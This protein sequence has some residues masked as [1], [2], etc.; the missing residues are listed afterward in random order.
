MPPAITTTKIIGAKMVMEAFN[1][2]DVD[3]VFGYPGGAVLYLYDEIYNQNYFKHILCRH[4]QG[5]IH[6]ADGYA[7]ASGK[8][9]VAI[10]TSGPGFTN[11]V[12]GIAT[13]FTD[14]IPL[15]VISG[16]VP[17]TQIGTDAFQEID[18]VGI[19][20]PCT[21]HNYLVKNIKELPRV[22]KE[23]FYIAQSGRP[24][25]VLI[26]LPKDVS[27]TLGEFNYPADIEL[28]TY[29][30]IV[31][32]NGRQISKLCEAM[33]NAKK[34]LFY[35]G[36]GAIIS[37][38]VEEIRKIMNLTKIPSIETL[39]ARGVSNDS[40]ELFL[41]MAGMHGSYA[42]NMA[43][44]ECDLLISLGARFDDRITSKLSEFAKNAKIAHIDVDPSSIGKIVNVDYPIVGDLKSICLDLIT[45]LKD[46]DKIKNNKWIEI[47]QN[48]KTKNPLKYEDSNEIL[49][50]Q[51]VIQK[52]GEI[53]KGD[54]IIST[55]VGQHQMWAA[56]FYPFSR[57]REFITSGGLGT[58]GFGF[59]AAIG[60][61]V[62]KPNLHS[63]NITGDGSIVMNIQE[64][65]TCV[66]QNISVINVIL[67]NSYL[68][69]VRQW[70][71]FFYD[72]RYSSV[73]LTHQPDFVKL[74]E[75]FG[76][77][78][79]KVN[80]KSEF[81]RAFKE[82]LKL[83]KVALLDVKIDRMESV[84]PMVPSGEALSSMILG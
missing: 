59:P 72:K 7:R 6:A 35:I 41:G 69:M 15:V 60:V 66:E 71:T 47:L 68:G 45:M 62:A 50:P 14:S 63:I 80:T 17:I 37:N 8:V 56:Q 42:A 52:I 82:A 24:G 65:V 57:T 55:D 9:G 44:C 34:P 10:I 13:A 38:A 53:I 78:G 2:E 31:K 43:I 70:Q 4:E 3:V 29:K 81:E 27:K 64:L 23:A 74:A 22:L 32:G 20:R 49:K 79:F 30:P 5:A 28:R 77:I 39:M 16:Q 61:K 18:A 1:K 83:N 73:D 54:G 58:M 48:Y 84:F 51:W 40:N 12:T 67:N 21:K 33:K 19:S 76:G 11:A 46:F 25:P 75:S 36:G 26:D